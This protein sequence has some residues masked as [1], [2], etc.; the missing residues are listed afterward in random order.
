MTAES[1]PLSVP[2]RNLNR[3]DDYFFERM[4]NS[5]FPKDEFKGH[6]G[7]VTGL[8]WSGN[9]KTLASTSVDQTARLWNVSNLQQRSS[10]RDHAKTVNALAISRDGR[11]MLS[12]S[13]D[14]TARFWNLA[15]MRQIGPPMSTF[16]RSDD[17]ANR[18]S[19]MIRGG[20]R[21]STVCPISREH[22]GVQPLRKA[23][24]AK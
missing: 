23:M 1:Q 3:R 11:T 5:G 19:N 16:I 14:R 18:M 7:H 24:Q 15:T 4:P 13:N 12:G 17:S 20:D 22:R 10:L 6:A 8:A 2:F 9:G 21:I